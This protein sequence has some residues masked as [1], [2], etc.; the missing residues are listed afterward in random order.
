MITQP[1]DIPSGNNI[2]VSG[3]IHES[4]VPD[5]TQS[6]I[7][8]Q[9]STCDPGEGMLT[10]SMAA[11]LTVASTS[12][13]LFANFLSKIEPKKVS[14][15]LNTKMRMM[16]VFRNKKDEHVTTTKNKARL[17]AQGYSQEE[18]IN[19]D[20]T[21]APV[22]RMEAIKIFL[23]FA[24]Y[25]NFKVYQMDVK[26]AF[27][28]GKL[29][30]EVY[31]K[32]P[33]S[34]ESSE[35]PDYVCKLDKAL[36]GLKQAPKAC[37][38]IFNGDLQEEAAPAGEQPGPL[39]PKTAKQLATKR[40][41]ERVYAAPV[42]KEDIN[43][44]FLRSHPPSWRQIALIMRNKLDIDQTDIDDLYNN[45]KT[46]S[47][48]LDN[49][50]LQQI[51]QDDLEELDIRWQVAMLTVRLSAYN[52]HMKGHF[53]KECKSGRNQGK[54]SYGDNGR[55]NATINEPSS[56]ALVAQDDLGGYD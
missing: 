17:V 2:E 36:Y 29:K 24:T 8:N 21:F 12:E 51:D 20:E 9:A 26:S 3:S 15:A 5:V 40:N 37:D 18:G 38:I 4:L 49:E 27:L 53:A 7:S 48:P 32:Q 13:C 44:K 45:L 46:T 10:K 42:S 56:Q 1:T 41:Q 31:V 6:H 50:D 14:E 35:F 22:A 25:M 28:N 39:T 11:K 30:E 55:R 16:H 47:H 23:A 34:F 19:Y 54:R 33:P 43:Q 52:Y